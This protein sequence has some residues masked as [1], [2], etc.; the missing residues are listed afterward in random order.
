[1][2]MY[3]SSFHNNKTSNDERNKILIKI[4]FP[5]YFHE[6]KLICI[7]IQLYYILK[8]SIQIPIQIQIE[9]STIDK[10]IK[11]INY[12]LD[13]MINNDFTFVEN[14]IKTDDAHIKYISYINYIFEIFI[15][16]YFNK[17]YKIRNLDTTKSEQKYDFTILNQY[18]ESINLIKEKF[19]TW[20][21]LF[22]LI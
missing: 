4:Y 15:N 19:L 17:L 21:N 2:D 10:F 8:M 18:E 20:I 5:T 16:K 1:M 11:D 3:L 13:E 14:K 9:L 7:I 12:L 22:D 6:D